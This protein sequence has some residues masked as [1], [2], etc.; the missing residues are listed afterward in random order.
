MNR[1]FRVLLILSSVL[2]LVLI[3]FLTSQVGALRSEFVGL[4][5]ALATKED[6]VRVS[7]PPVEFFHEEKCT[8]CHAERRFAGEHNTRGEMESALAHM[9]SLPDARFSDE[10]MG[11]IHASLQML[12]CKSCHGADRLRTLALKTSEERMEIIRRMVNK[13]GSNLTEDDVSSIHAS[14]QQIWGF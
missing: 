6:L 14:F 3:A 11:K 9:K 5:G 8:G 7:V 12:R 2:S 4:R 13:P 1:T 10:D